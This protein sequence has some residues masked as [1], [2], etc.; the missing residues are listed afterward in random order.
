MCGRR[1]RGWLSV[2]VLTVAGWSHADLTARDLQ[3]QARY[4]EL[5]S[6]IDSA[7][8]AQDLRT[9]QGFGSRLEGSA[10][11]A[12]TREWVKSRLRA[13]GF[14]LPTE[15][16]F[17]VTVPD[18]DSIAHIGAV[19]AYPLWP[20][21]VSTS[22]LDTTALLVDGGD[23]SLAALTG[24]VVAGSIVVLPFAYRDRW[25]QSVQLGAKALVFTDS[26][27]STREEAEY[28][29][30]E[31]PIQ[32]PRFWVSK[33]DVPAL[34]R[35]IG[36]VAPIQC[37]QQWVRRPSENIIAESPGRQPGTILVAAYADSMSIV[38]GL[39]P[40]AQ[41][42]AGLVALME[43][44]VTAVRNPDRRTIRFVLLGGHCLGLKG[45]RTYV[46]RWLDEGGG[47]ILAGITVDL[48]TGSLSMGSFGRGWLYEFRDEARDHLLPLSRILR[49]HA[50]IM[51][52][53][54]GITDD[55]VCLIDPTSNSDGR[56]WRNDV[57]GRLATDAEPF[58][59]ANSPVLTLATSDDLR[60]VIDTPADTLENLDLNVLRSQAQR[61]ACLLDHLLRDTDNPRDTSLYRVPK[62][63][64]VPRR[65]TLVGGYG[66]VRG[67]VVTF[68][69]TKSFV[70]DVPVT[71][72]VVL[73]QGR[74]ATNMGVR[75][76]LVELADSKGHFSFEGL[77][78]VNSY[79]DAARQPTIVGAYRF[80]PSGEIIGAPSEGLLGSV[81][82]PT[83]FDLTTTERESPLV[84]FPC[85]TVDVLGLLDPQDLDPIRGLSILD[86]RSDAEPPQFGMFRRSSDPEH[87]GPSQVD[88]SLFVNA[89][90]SF[91]LI[92]QSTT[93][94]IRMVLGGRKGLTSDRHRV[95]A[96]LD[97]AQ[98]MLALNRDRLAR[99]ARYR[100]ISPDV[101]RL[102]RQAESEA[103]LATD[104]LQRR[105]YDQA[106]AH[107][108]AAWGLALRA[109]PVIRGT[110]N[111]LV[112]GVLFYLL[113][114]I[115]FSIFVENL[116]IGS[117]Q[118]THRVIGTLV[119]FLLSYLL[120]RSLHPAF[121]LVPN[122]WIIF[123]AFV[124]GALSLVVSVFI[125]GKFD[126]S[127]TALQ[128][129]S[130]AAVGVDR[131]K[132]R[133][134]VAAIPLAIGNLRRRRLR[135]T[136]TTLTLAV[137]TFIVLGFTSI[138]PQLQLQ[139][140]PTGRVGTFAGVLMRYPDLSPLSAQLA[141]S[142]TADLP[143]GVLARRVFVYGFD[144]GE[145]P[146]LS[147]S[148]ASHTVDLKAIL[149]LDAAEPAM[150]SFGVRGRWMQRNERGVCLVSQPTA[151]SLKVGLGGAIIVAG[152]AMK[153][154]G[155]YDPAPINAYRDLDG[156]G[157]FPGDFAL[158][159][160]K[161]ET[162][163]TGNSAFVPIERLDS[164][165]CMVV[166][167]DD[168]LALGGQLRGAAFD[169]GTQ[170][171]RAAVSSLIPRLRL[172]L[173]ASSSA[174]SGHQ[175]SQFS[176]IQGSQGS[177][178]GMILAQ[179]LIASLFVLNTMVAGVMERQ[180]EI[181]ILSS[182]GLAPTQIGRLFFVESAVYG[183]LG[184]VLGYFL[185]QVVARI[186]LS[187][188]L[189]TGL[190]LNFSSM[191]AVLSAVLVMGV[192]LLSTIYPARMAAKLAAPA[193][194]ASLDATPPEG[195]EWIVQLPFTVSRR[196]SEAV[197]RHFRQWFQAFE[198]LTI[199][200]LV[201]E[202]TTEADGH[203]DTTAWLAPFDL[204][205]SQRIRLEALPSPAPDID[206][207]VL[208]IE[209][210]SGE[211]RNWHRANGPFLES[212]RRQ[213]LSWRTQG[214]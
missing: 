178:L 205:V 180:R 96:A 209:R 85:A 160:R 166:S 98:T 200:N 110:A 116:A 62:M 152:Q 86:S 69:P 22:T 144:P 59:L 185:A 181:G 170:D 123:I 35:M 140:R 154:V 63:P 29:L 4:R 119:I 48:S 90:Q 12:R 54:L 50:S 126:S 46:E 7:H 124:M 23:G 25:R 134:G 108:R 37:T 74:H 100:I 2:A 73:L 172:N 114:L 18:P 204:G 130:N 155:I 91:R 36:T 42:S 47:P 43:C 206:E 149:G 111:D 169:F 39:A 99:F 153:V 21:V 203:V 156:D 158:N 113:L 6:S 32:I 17:D 129:E 163:R 81:D 95:V 71:D 193:R 184:S 57:P 11:S 44:L 115:P 82:Y 55:R 77:P 210:L 14:G 56:P 202:G 78:V 171:A 72:A 107:A 26:G 211:P 157:L 94:D 139:A 168:A 5:A 151:D 191:S 208:R 121:E 173:Y 38:P 188:G 16:S 194:D 148:T 34:R 106:D 186:A 165:A 67:T 13:M 30:A 20:N 128:L 212:I 142:L 8:L 190:Y 9:I 1:L 109:Y 24:K 28:K 136:L 198:E 177:G 122:P 118:L 141:E 162:S 31:A 132:S 53:V 147:V 68:D 145:Q 201:T 214:H 101:E 80:A 61:I 167:A 213:F 84:I 3:A 137:M 103:S 182:L 58:A 131:Q 27:D 65:M 104:T 75:G 175:I 92:G 41:Q 15:Q 87:P 161:R 127:L 52:P 164:A 138:V 179:L 192:V 195:D 189:F 135:T 117:R 79:A 159:R 45:A 83:A 207:L 199:G 125:L 97:S 196:E 40:G 19:R 143:Q 10:G 51:A 66:V 49:G 197:L 33:Q 89:G 105:A 70:P 112:S 133:M 120:L 102:Q 88:A 64:S 183:V 150:P 146:G 176:A 93:G 174:A 60:R 76:D 187:T